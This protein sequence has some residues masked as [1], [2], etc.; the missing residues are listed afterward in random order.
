M[1]RPKKSLLGLVGLALALPA[2]AAIVMVTVTDEA[3]AKRFRFSK[4]Q[5]DS[6]ADYSASKHREGS[7]ADGAH[8]ADGD[9]PSFTFRPRY[10]G[11]S[12]EDE[13][14]DAD[15]AAKNADAEQGSQTAGSVDDNA[16]PNADEAPAKIVQKAPAK[17]PAPEKPKNPIAAAHPGMDVVV[18]EAGCT[19]ASERQ[20]AVYI[21]VTTERTAQSIAEVKPTASAGSASD[22]DQ[23]VIK[24]VGGCYDTPKLY[25]SALAT[26][27]MAAAPAGASIVPLN[28][29]P[30]DTG[31]GAWMRRIDKNR[32]T[33][34]Q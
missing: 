4:N 21:Q 8:T 5:P 10:K 28:A 24:C 27:D 13:N 2:T 29:K 31:S 23:A 17:Q 11:S 22:A 7:D 18:C 15:Q 34:G 14:T 3:S 30:S 9:G 25:H 19:N 1:L 16:A 20:E 6:H 33:E 26:P 32:A 12:S